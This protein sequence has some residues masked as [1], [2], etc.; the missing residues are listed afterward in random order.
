MAVVQKV[1]KVGIGMLLF[2]EVPSNAATP[3]VDAH[4]L[5]VTCTKITGYESLEAKITYKDS[6]VTER[7]TTTKFRGKLES[8]TFYSVTGKV[9]GK[10]PAKN[11]EI[12]RSS[13]TSKGVDSIA[14]GAVHRG[15]R[16]DF[17]LSFTAS[18]TQ[19]TVKRSGGTSE[20]LFLTACSRERK[21]AS[22]NASALPPR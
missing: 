20:T 5:A 8:A 9:V 14:F 12:T 17:N 7:P 11:I 6:D 16:Y 4:T 3:A 22:G 18:T 15:T 1:L 2:V 10:I 19:S 13:D 21:Q